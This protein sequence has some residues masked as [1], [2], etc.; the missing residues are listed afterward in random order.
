MV[1]S[2]SA[3]VAALVIA[4]AL[5]LDRAV[6]LG[7]LVV[8]V[9]PDCGVGNQM[10]HYAAGMGYALQNFSV[11]VRGLNDVG[12]P[13]HP[14]SVFRRV[15]DV[16][17]QPLPRCPESVTGGSFLSTNLAFMERF[18]PPHST[19]WPLLA[20]G[21]RSVVVTGC[22][23]SFKYFRSVPH[24]LFRPRRLEEAKRWLGDI[25]SVVHVR[26]SDKITEGSVAPLDYY[27]RIV[28]TLG[29]FAVCTDDPAW[30][31]RH[32]VFRNAT[33]SLHDDPAFDLALMAAATDAIVIG[34]GTFGWWGA[35]L[36]GARMK[37][38]YPVQY[39]GRLAAGFVADDYFPGDWTPV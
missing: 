32:A 20:T 12:H 33:V 24:P 13:A 7:F 31:R 16:I 38:Y 9:K 37:Y 25:A 2:A 15:V 10:F 21:G 14:G 6:P 5:V 22:M 3:C 36:S 4:W 35:Y 30:V 1:C 19:F 18:T 34:T 8:D 17:G 11:C 23:Q 29:R 27:E 26:R 28:P 39:R